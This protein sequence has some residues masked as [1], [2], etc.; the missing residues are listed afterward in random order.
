MSEAA[1]DRPTKFP[2]RCRPLSATGLRTTS[3][4]RSPSPGRDQARR[5]SRSRRRASA[6]ATSSATTAPPSSGVTRTGRPGPRPRSSRATS[7]SEQLFSSMTPRPPLGNRG[8]RPGGRR[9]DRAVLE[10]PLLPGRQVLDVR[11]ARH[12]R[13]QAAHAGR[14][15][16]VHGLRQG[17]PGAQGLHRPAARAR[18]VHRAAVLRAA[19]RRARRHQVRR[20]RRR[21]RLRPDRPRHDRRREVQEPQAG[22]RPRHGPGQAGARQGLRRRRDDQHRSE[23]AVAKVKD[24][25]DG[26]GA[27]VYLEG[28]GHPSAVAQGLNLLRKLGTYVEYSVFGSD[29]TVDWSIISDDKELDVRGAHLGPTAGR[30]RSG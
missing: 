16:G 1:A 23:D 27:D 11:A 18:R 15:G 28:T 4:R 10:V 26:Y 6:P 12:V 9:A 22:H 14:H 8:R 29:V 25:T 24:L 17:R 30:P 2:R 7:S 21:R 20:R 5:W 19:R 13:L 3:W